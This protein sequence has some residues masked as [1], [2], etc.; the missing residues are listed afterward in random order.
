[1]DG[2]FVE[3][4]GGGRGSFNHRFAQ[5]SRDGHQHWNDHYPTDVFPFTD[6]PE[7]DPETG[8]TEGLLDRAAATG[9]V[10]KVFHVVTS[11]EYWNRAA[12]LMHTDADG[13]RDVALPDTSRVYL[14]ASAQH[15]PRPL[16]PSPGGAPGSAPLH[17][18]NPLD[19]R[20]A[21]RALALALDRW[22][23]DGVEPPPSACPRIADGT[24]VPPEKAGWPAVPGVRFP[25]VRNQPP[26]LDAG[27]EAARGILSIEPPRLGRV[28]PALVPAVDAD[29]ND[30]AGIRLPEV[31]VPL[32]TQTGWNWRQPSAGAPD[33]LAPY[34]GSYFPFARTKAERE[35]AGDPRPSVEE[36]YRG[37]EEY[38]GKASEAALALVHARFLLPEDVPAV[39]ERA[40]AH[41]DWRAR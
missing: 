21:I 40:A 2:V 33:A 38:L 32:A 12:S 7:T 25:H 41:W 14:L 3:V 39:L 10:P 28:F 29:G 35:A 19:F 8:A 24:L 18:T 23:A 37:R 16:P 15:G 1:F 34:V 5:A 20:P 30:R 6:A 13:A 17:A 22:V 4:A 26:R 36:R 9:T 11:Y 27:P 31:A